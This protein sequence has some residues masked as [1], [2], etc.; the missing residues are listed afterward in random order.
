MIPA[1]AEPDVNFNDVQTWIQRAGANA[2]RCFI[3]R[4]IWSAHK[5]GSGRIGPIKV[6]S[7]EMTPDVQISHLARC[8]AQ[9]RPR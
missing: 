9:S 7:V 2:D 6:A 8:A 3:C 5:D 1:K 4:S